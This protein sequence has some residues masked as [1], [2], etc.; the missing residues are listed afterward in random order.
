[1]Y[2]RRPLKNFSGGCAVRKIQFKNGVWVPSS[3]MERAIMRYINIEAVDCLLPQQSRRTDFTTYQ[4]YVFD[5]DGNMLS[6]MVSSVDSVCQTCSTETG[7]SFL[8]N[9]CY[10]NRTCYIRGYTNPNNHCQKCLPGRSMRTWSPREDNR[11]PIVRIKQTAFS[12]IQGDTI[13]TR[14][15]ASDPEGSS[16]NFSVDRSDAYVSRQ[17]TFKWKSNVRSLRRNGS[18]EVFRV[19]ITDKCDGK[20]TIVLLVVLYQCG[21]KNNGECVSRTV[22]YNRTANGYECNCPTSYTGARCESRASACRSNP[23]YHRHTCVDVGDGF[24]CGQCP[25]GM[26]GNGITCTRT[27]ESNPCFPGVRCTDLAM[28]DPAN[29]QN[30]YACGQCPTN[31]LGDGR[32]CKAQRANMCERNVCSALVACR[33]TRR[34]PYYRCGACPNGYLGNGT[35]CTAYCKPACRNNGQCVRYNKCRCLGGYEGHRC[36]IPVC[37]PPCQNGGACL[38]G[39]QCRCTPNYKGKVCAKPKCNPMCQN[40]GKCVRPGVCRCRARHGGPRC[41]KAV[42]RFQCQNGGVCSVNNRCKCPHGFHGRRCQF[43]KCTRN[44]NGRGYCRTHDKCTCRRGYYGPNCQYAS[45]WPKCPE[46]Q[47]CPSSSVCRCR[48]T[49]NGHVCQVRRGHRRKLIRNQ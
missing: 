7:C 48:R 36:E 27:C 19:S 1:M 34:Y 26:T 43:V 18:S 2:L 20:R 25:T 10:I 13:F 41:E 49:T 12:I 5:S 38:P 28:S 30:A 15:N 3:N 33:E 16:L 32:R 39:N 23:C 21:C 14:I 46:G 35:T 11:P 8:N 42:C 9:T 44:C 47:R 29:T 6:R 17:G 37:N 24:R 40:G 22:S 4:A 45:C 31:Y